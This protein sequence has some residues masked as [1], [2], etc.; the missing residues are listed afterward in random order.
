MSM[1]EE[2]VQG[3]VAPASPLKR[4]PFSRI[5]WRGLPWR[6]IGGVALKT[7]LVGVPSVILLCAIWV[8]AYA[9]VEPPTTLTMVRRALGGADVRREVVPL[10]R[11][12][13]HLIRAVIAAE[14]TRFCRHRGF[15]RVEIARAMEQARGGG[16]LR[17]AST[18]SQ[19]TAK[20]AFLWTGGGWPRKA[21]EAGLTVAI[22]AAWP[23][24]RIL[25]IYLN[26]AEWGDGLFGAEAAAQARFGK[27]AADL[28]A[29]EAA[30]LAAVLP[31]PNR[32]RLDPPGEYVTSRA[33]TLEARMA[34]VRR[35]ALANCVLDGS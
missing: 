11:I 26:A 35:D 19:Q 10:E 1:A 9:V 33:A 2:R 20:N 34:V 24:R 30:L 4:I 3:D 21:A 17:G 22:E 18:L 29:R 15:D 25:E 27:S 8:F 28:T 23:K 12:S 13:P 32:W 6:R 5:P 31:S 16:R 14:D 7:V